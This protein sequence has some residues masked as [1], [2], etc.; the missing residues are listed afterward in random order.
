MADKT[1]RHGGPVI[2]QPH[3][4]V[5]YADLAAT[6]GSEGAR[7]TVGKALRSGLLN[8][9]EQ[10][11]IEQTLAMARRRANKREE[12]VAA[13]LDNVEKGNLQGAKDALSTLKLYHDYCRG[14]V[15][16]APLQDKA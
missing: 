4:C 12:I 13:V 7:E 3:F 5:Q 10:S 2:R 6:A 15:I 11:Y 16:V 9:E 8:S 14:G 1:T